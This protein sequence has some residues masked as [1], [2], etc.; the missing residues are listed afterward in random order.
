MDWTFLYRWDIYYFVQGFV[1]DIQTLIAN[2]SP[3]SVSVSFVLLLALFLFIE[4]KRLRFGSVLFSVTA[5][6][7]GTFVLT[8]TL[9]GRA[10][11]VESSW[12][13]LFRIYQRALND[14]GGAKLDIFYNIVLYY[15]VG[16]FISRYKR[17]GLDVAVLF[18]MPLM[19]EILQLITGRGM[20]ELSD[21]INNFVGG[22]GGLF[23]ARL[24]CLFCR[25]IKGTR[26]EG[27]VERAE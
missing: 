16:L 21:I 26:K 5:A 6:M 18:A 22:V 4:R 25:Y 9:L 19:I 20:F 13:Q 8:V 12:D 10:S 1:I 23:T 17:T 2:A 27:Q 11:G 3:V 15:P 7:Y 24:I 14:D